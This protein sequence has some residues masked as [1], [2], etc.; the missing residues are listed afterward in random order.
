MPEIQARDERMPYMMGG[1]AVAHGFGEAYYIANQSQVYLVAPGQLDRPK[2][3][4]IARLRA[5]IDTA[6]SATVPVDL[7]R[8]VPFAARGLGIECVREPRRIVVREG[9]DELALHLTADG[10]VL[11]AVALCSPYPQASGA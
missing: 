4:P 2:D 8:A 6:T 5:A 1:I 11:R 7:A 10:H 3:P 9:R